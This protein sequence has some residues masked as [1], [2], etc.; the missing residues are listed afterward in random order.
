MSSKYRFVPDIN[1]GFLTDEDTKK[2]I[3][4]L[5]LSMFTL[6]VASFV[7]SYAVAALVGTIIRMFAPTLLNSADIVAILNNVISI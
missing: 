1:T 7:F 6:E 4:R 3:S 5:A 2:Y